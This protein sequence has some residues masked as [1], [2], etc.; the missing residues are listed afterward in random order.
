MFLIVLGREPKISLAELESLYGANNVAQLSD[1][2]ATV[3]TPT[4]HLSRLG[5]TIKAGQILDAPLIKTLLD[6]PSGKIT[7]GFSDYSPR[8]T[9]RT[10]QTQA[11]KLKSILK[12]QGRSIRI[13]PNNADAALSSATSHHNQLGEKQNHIEVLIYNNYTALSIGTQNITAY[14]RRDQARPARD[15]FVGM[16]PPKLA[17]ILINIATGPISAEHSDQDHGIV[18]DPF[19][20]TGTILQESLLMNYPAYGTDLSE[21]M[22]AYAKKNLDWLTETYSRPSRHSTTSEDSTPPTTPKYTLEPGDAT[23]H[24]WKLPINFVASEVYLGQPFSA[25]PSDIKLRQV[26]F[27]TKSILIS[28]LK[29]IAPQLDPDTTLAL[30]IPAWRRPSGE[31]SCLDIVDEI[32]KLRYN[33][34]KF[35]HAT[36]SD[37]LYYRENQTVAR[38]IILLKKV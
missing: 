4:L 16:L 1:T 30:A 23:T 12:R 2:I 7:I 19:C 29:N 34:H 13:I 32:Q 5:G 25:P 28:F 35:K 22:I 31:F 11:L 10:A 14:A 24:T 37:L 17:Q 21:K 20:G 38:Q 27:T 33:V 36:P 8:A 9:A 6:L 18:L 26:Q 3:N 15:A